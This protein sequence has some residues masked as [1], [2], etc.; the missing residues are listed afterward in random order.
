MTR[1]N[2]PQAAVERRCPNCGTRVAR[3]AESCFMCGY[4]LRIKPKRKQ[5]VSWIDALLVVAIL[6]VLGV[7]WRVGAQPAQSDL[8]ETVDAILPSEIPVLGPTDTPEPTVESSAEP[9]PLPPQTTQLTHEVRAGETLLGIA[10]F[11]N[12]TVEE[13]QAA[14]DMDDENIFVG[15]RLIIPSVAVAPAPVEAAAVD[16]TFNYTVQGGD[17]VTSIAIQFGTTI[18]EILTANNLTQSDLLRPGDVLLVPV[19]NVPEA[20]LENASAATAETSE[21]TSSAGPQDAERIYI[22]PRLIGP[23]NEASLTREEAVLLRWVSVDVLQPDEWYVLQIN[24]AGGATQNLFPIWTKTTSERL[25]QDLA[26]PAGASATY[27]WQVSVI[28][29]QSGEGGQYQLEPV[30]PPSDVLSFTWE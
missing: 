9:T 5:R 19:R 7:W 23:P 27:R 24:P 30:S 17:T 15:D 3:D 13:I 10:G 8:A 18:D 26:P 25:A 28:R 12:V 6:A 29:V 16:S 1:D 20:V 2:F 22:A 14:N 21:T 4:D 11:Y